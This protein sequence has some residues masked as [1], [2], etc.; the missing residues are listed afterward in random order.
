MM[1]RRRPRSEKPP[2]EHEIDRNFEHLAQFRIW[3]R[4]H[5]EQEAWRRADEAGWAVPEFRR[6]RVITKEQWDYFAARF[7]RYFLSNAELK[8][9]NRGEDTY[10]GKAMLMANLPEADASKHREEGP[11][12]AFVRIESR[13][14]GFILK[15]AQEACS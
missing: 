7:G 14:M 3:Y 5:G 4:E 1:R 11:Q 2:T 10:P 8:K 12:I 6:N 15:V 13:T 9:W